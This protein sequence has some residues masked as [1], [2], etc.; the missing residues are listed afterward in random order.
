MTINVCTFAGRLGKDSETKFVPSGDCVT[1]WSLAVDVGY[2]ERK[3][4]LWLRCAAWGTRWE[5]VA[6]YLKKGASVTCTGEIDLREYEYNGETRQSLELRV[7]DLALQ[8]GERRSEGASQAEQ[9]QANGFREPTPA[10]T[11]S[12]PPSQQELDDDIPF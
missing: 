4:T 7:Q 1:N 10:Q 8:G 9:P 12:S 11:N 5:K 3:H 2:K 6:P